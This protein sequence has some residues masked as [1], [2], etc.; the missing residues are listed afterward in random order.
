[1]RRSPLLPIFLTVF[2]DVLGLT[3]VLP[4]LPFYAEHF[5]ASELVVGVL[6]ASYAVCQLVS[7]PILGRISDR[8]GRKPTL[9]ASQTGTFIG[10]LVLGSA[11]SLW[12][13]FLGR[14]IDG[15]TAGNLTIA[16]AYISDVTRPEERTRAF[17]LIG[18]AFGSGFLLGPAITGELASRFGYGAPAYG[19]AALSLTS[20]FLTATLLPAKPIAPAA[21]PEAATA[22]PRPAAIG[23]GDAFRRYF[24]RPLARRRL[25]EFFAFSLSFSTLIGGLAL[26]LERRFSFGVKETGY[27]YAFSG[28]IGGSI[29]GGLIGRLARRYGEERLALV[30]FAT[31]VIG[32]GLLGAAYTLPMLLVLVAIAAF[33]AAVVRPSV[34]T[35]LTKSVGRDEQGAALGVSQ[36]LASI[37][38]IVGPI[39]AGWLI[40]HRALAAYGLM[41]ASFAALG[42]VLG[43][44]KIPVGEPVEL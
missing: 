40:E 31:M 1:M 3:L 12:M 5:G 44:Q 42:F 15:L 20:I 6:A 14:I 13:L 35:L 8:A 19:A 36:S 17:G 22:A 26:F 38:Q 18:I 21:S 25:L 11:S 16:Q 9:L 7:G 2:V 32:Y 33:G 39:G 43:L 29:Q 41:A 10:F 28:L 30:G 34:T 23:R 4:L 37:S 24:D 27:L